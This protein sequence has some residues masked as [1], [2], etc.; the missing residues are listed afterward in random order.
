[1]VHISIQSQ[2]IARDW[3]LVIRAAPRHPLAFRD[4]VYPIS[5]V[6]AFPSIVEEMN[7]LFAYKATQTE[8]PNSNTREKVFSLVIIAS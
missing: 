6:W 4:V 5:G 7:G 8:R 1:M 2:A 3:A